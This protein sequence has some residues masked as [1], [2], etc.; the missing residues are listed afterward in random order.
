[1]SKGKEVLIHGRECQS[2]KCLFVC[3]GKP[4]DVKR[5]VNYKFFGL[6]VEMIKV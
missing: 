3:N 5:C 6:K 4:I 1:M 2:C